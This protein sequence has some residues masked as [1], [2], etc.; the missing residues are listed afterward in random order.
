MEKIEHKCTKTFLTHFIL[1]FLR[2]RKTANKTKKSH[3]DNWFVKNIL[4]PQ[5]RVNEI[6]LFQKTEGREQ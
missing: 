2:G 1:V 4:L 6:A 5:I 3:W